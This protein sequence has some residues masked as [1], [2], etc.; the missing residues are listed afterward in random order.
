LVGFVALDFEKKKGKWGTKPLQM[1]L[2]MRR[3]ETQEKI[4][5]C[6]ISS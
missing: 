2:K 6:M 3:I 1:Q 4:A 5:S